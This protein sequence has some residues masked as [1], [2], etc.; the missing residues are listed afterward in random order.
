MRDVSAVDPTI[1]KHAGRWWLF[2][3]MKLHPGISYSDELFL[4]YADNPLS[5]EWTP[6]PMNPVVSDARKSRP[7][8]AVLDMDGKLFRLSQN[9]TRGY[10]YAVNLHEIVTLSETEYREEDVRSFLPD[11]D[12]RI[13]GLH[14]LAHAGDLTVIDARI[15]RRRL[16]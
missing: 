2:L 6:H 4:Y 14:T 15:R 8:G 11:W 1:F 16:M 12:P 7:A 13:A 10:G 9:C 5:D 3:A